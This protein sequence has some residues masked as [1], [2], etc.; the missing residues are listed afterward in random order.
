MFDGEEPLSQYRLLSFT[1]PIDAWYSTREGMRTVPA[2]KPEQPVPPNVQALISRLEQERPVHWTI[3]AMAFLDGDDES[4]QQWEASLAHAMSRQL[5]D[6]WSNSTQIFNNIVAVT[7]YMEYRLPGNLFDK[8]IA[9]YIDRKMRE[10]RVPNWILLGDPG[11]G[12]LKIL[13]RSSKPGGIV[14]VFS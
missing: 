12:K 5:T 3:G 2:P 9:D 7:Y 10:G 1:E 4:R 11:M 14:E 8:D 13:V 6:G